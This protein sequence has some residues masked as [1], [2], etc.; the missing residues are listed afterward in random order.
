MKP[1]TDEESILIWAIKAIAIFTVFFAHMPWSTPDTYMSWLYSSLGSIGVPIFLFLSGYL[2]FGSKK[3]FIDKLPNLMIP[4]LIWGTLTFVFNLLI[5]HNSLSLFTMVSWLKWVLGS[6]TWYYFI[7]VLLMCTLMSRYIN[8]W[9]LISISIVAIL[10]SDVIPYNEVFT[11]SLNPF[12]FVV[13]FSAGRL[14]RSKEWQ[15]FNNQGG[16]YSALFIMMALLL[17]INVSYFSIFC[18][19]FSFSCMVILGNAFNMIFGNKR[20]KVSDAMVS[21]GKASFVIYLVHMPI[22]GIIDARCI[23]AAEHF[24]VLIAFG[25]TCLL[26]FGFRWLLHFLPHHKGRFLTNF[27]FR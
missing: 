20:N 22:A 2:D 15:I 27:G 6:G 21:V 16:I 12:F 17:R 23:G 14:V 1:I 10:F 7:P 9:I 5:S 25:V 18:I 8:N 3:R 26:V 11:R 13:Y 4:L 24:K 19:P